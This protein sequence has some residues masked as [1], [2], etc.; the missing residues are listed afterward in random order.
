VFAVFQIQNAFMLVLTL[1][2]FVF[3]AWAFIDAVARR[4]DAFVAADKLTKPAWLII[5]G[6]AVAAHMLIWNP[7]SFLNLIGAV[8]AIVYVVDA[9]PAMR[10]LTGR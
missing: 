1:V 5:L 2:L 8:A 3:Q 9:R 7:L 10:A 6:L 4:P